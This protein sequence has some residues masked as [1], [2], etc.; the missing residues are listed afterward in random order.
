MKPTTRRAERRPEIITKICCIHSYEQVI[1][2]SRNESK[3]EFLEGTGTAKVA[4][5]TLFDIMAGSMVLDRVNRV[6]YASLSERTCLPLTER[7]C[8]Q[9]GYRL[10]SFHATDANNASIYHT[11][12]L[13]AIGLVSSA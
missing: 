7:W 12:V 2:L 5:A 11:N 1:D 3:G 6:C 4:L 8:Q 9:F 10:V 13:M